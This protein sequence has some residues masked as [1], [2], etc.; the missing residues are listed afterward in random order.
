M[1][2]LVLNE[3]IKQ[4]KE[5]S[6]LAI[7]Q[8]VKDLRSRGVDICHFGFGQSPFPVPE[9]VSKELALNSSKKEYLPTKGLLELRIMISKYL[10]R[11]FQT[12]FSSENILI[13]P[14]SK[15]LLYQ[16]LLLIKGTVI[17]PAPSWVSYRPQREVSANSYSIMKT[18]KV[19]DYN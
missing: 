18:Q 6:T 7:N 19:N 11:N 12:N 16:L 3:N 8:K 13:G 1:K 9:I 2:E 10:K 15:E 17:I 14:G 5:S 4:I